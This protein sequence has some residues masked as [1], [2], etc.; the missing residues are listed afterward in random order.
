MRIAVIDDGINPS[1][2]RLKPLFID[3]N[4]T[5][6][7]EVPA[8]G[9]HGTTCAAIILK[10]APDAEIGSIRILNKTDNRGSIDNLE[11]AIEW[12][13]EN[14]VDI[15]HMSIGS[16]EIGDRQR[17][18][19]VINHGIS[20]GIIFVAALSNKSSWSYPA[21]FTGVISVK[22][23][24]SLEGNNYIQSSDEGVDF[25]ACST[26]EIELQEGF[27][28]TNQWG[29][30]YAA[31]VITSIVHIIYK[32]T[33]DR[34]LGNIRN[35]LIDRIGATEVKKYRSIDFFTDD[36]DASIVIA[37]EYNKIPTPEHTNLIGYIYDGI[38]GEES[39]RLL[40]DS[41]LLVWDRSHIKEAEDNTAAIEF[42]IPVIQITGEEGKVLS[43][44]KNLKD[45]FNL[46]EYPCITVTNRIEGIRYGF[47]ILEN[48]N[49][50]SE[51]ISMY[52]YRCLIFYS[53]Y[54]YQYDISLSID[55][56]NCV[57]KFP[58]KD[59]SVTFKLADMNYNDLVRLTEEC[60]QST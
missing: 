13:I 26:H 41:G 54:P 19:S 22:H 59:K 40:A 36:S 10:Y 45:A 2:H 12:C 50:I 34:R 4:L 5:D 35:L 46:N 47:E 1:L 8:L 43:F 49:E 39:Y 24:P 32:E 6:D 16:S 11:K 44:G 15:V 56:E 42:D 14:R 27:L 33:T 3:M 7:N 29:N 38:L 48:A 23:N 9:S 53:D 52:D 51:V 60:S 58:E 21:C 17:L 55:N 18:Q 57:F 25:E 37:N 20:K 31:P 30:S 28:T